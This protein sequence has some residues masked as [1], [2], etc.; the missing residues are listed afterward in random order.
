M[1]CVVIPYPGHSFDQMFFKWS[2]FFK[3][4]VCR[5]SSY[6]LKESFKEIGIELLPP[7]P[8]NILQCNVVLH[9]GVFRKD[10]LYKYPNKYHFYMAIEA[11]IIAISHTRKKMIKMASYVY[12]AVFTT[13]GGIDEDRIYQVIWPIDFPRE[14]VAKK[15]V[16]F[17][18]KKLVCMFCGNKYAINKREQYSERR[19]IIQYFEEHESD[20]F[21]LYGNGWDKLYK[22]FRIYRGPIKD[23]MGISAGYLFSF[24]LENE[25]HIK[26]CLSEKIFDAMI[27]GTV[28]IYE[29]IDDI[30]DYVPANCFIKY[31]DFDSIETL[32]KYLKSMTEE[33]YMQYKNNIEQYILSD[34]TRDMFS[35]KNMRDQIVRAYQEQTSPKKHRALWLLALYAVEQK[36]YNILCRLQKYFLMLKMTIR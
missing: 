36:I 23:K 35:A 11:S 13:Q 33:E 5:Y 3:E 20:D 2:P 7:S 29:G 26:G 24:C 25:K 8:E 1:K 9:F 32:V 30:E 21:D 12:D 10:I 22:G 19:N 17:K 31:S 6:M 34:K 15:D 27:A 28:P 16:P 14:I 18:N 4:G